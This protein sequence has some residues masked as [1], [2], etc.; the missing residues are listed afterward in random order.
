M[1]HLFSKEFCFYEKMWLIRFFIFIPGGTGC[2]VMLNK[3]RK[4][5]TLC[6]EHSEGKDWKT[7]TKSIQINV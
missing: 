7:V 1:V 2:V 4:I 3:I 5:V 6:L